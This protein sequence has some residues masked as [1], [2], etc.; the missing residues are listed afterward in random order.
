[1]SKHHV[2]HNRTPGGYKL[3]RGLAADASTK[4]HDYIGVDKRK[5]RES[6]S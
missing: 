4:V 2:K 1:M 3:A 6:K 5:E